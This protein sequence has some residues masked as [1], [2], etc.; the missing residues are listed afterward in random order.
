MQDFNKYLYNKLFSLLTGFLL[1]LFLNLVDVNILHYRLE[2]LDLQRLT[3]NRCFSLIFAVFSFK[4][5]Y[6]HCSFC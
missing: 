4:S 1:E 6:C 2:I 5:C 3:S